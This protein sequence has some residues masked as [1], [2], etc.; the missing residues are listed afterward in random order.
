[1]SLHKVHFIDGKSETFYDVIC[2]PGGTYF[3]GYTDCSNTKPI[4]IP[5]TSVLYVELITR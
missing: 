2:Q 5:L 3:K 4:C 1:M